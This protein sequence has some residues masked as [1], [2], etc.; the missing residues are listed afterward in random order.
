MP[1]SHIQTAPLRRKAGLV[2]QLR[3]VI[4]LIATRRRER[5]QLSTLD[6]HMLR[7]IGVDAM[8]AQ[9]E[10]AKPFWRS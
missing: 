2:A 5:L 9:A 1:Q 8:A 6:P 10:C 4:V 3:D 7:D